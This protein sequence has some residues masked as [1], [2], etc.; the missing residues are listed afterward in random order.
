M[1]RRS[2][3]LG[4][5]ALGA[6]VGLSTLTVRADVITVAMDQQINVG[7][8]NVIL[9]D[10]KTP[11]GLDRVTFENESGLGFARFHLVRDNGMGSYYNGPQVMLN[12]LGNGNVD[13]S[14]PT[15]KLEVDVRFHI[16]P[17]DYPPGTP[18]TSMDA[19]IGIYLFSANGGYRRIAY[20]FQ[21]L[22]GDPLYP[23]W[24]HLDVDPAVPAPPKIVIDESNF[25]AANVASIAFYGTNWAGKGNDFI[26]FRRLVITTRMVPEPASLALAGLGMLICLSVARP[27]KTR[28]TTDRADGSRA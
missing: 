21:A 18:P 24:K 22:T 12:R 3:C 20:P 17:D 28:P 7:H 23:V 5:A 27:G 2:L 1:F 16:D 10:T 14:D 11:A 4:A 26:D 19:P 8:G 9:P 15:A 6:L 13:L 25:D